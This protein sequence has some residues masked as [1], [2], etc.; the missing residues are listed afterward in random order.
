[1]PVK[2]GVY[3]WALVEEYICRCLEEEYRRRYTVREE[4][5]NVFLVS[6]WKE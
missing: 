1:M 2:E 6:S 5:R 3:S 4:G